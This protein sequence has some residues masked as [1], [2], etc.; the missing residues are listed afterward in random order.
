MNFLIHHIKYVFIPILFVLLTAM[1]PGPKST[2]EGP[3]SPFE[4]DKLEHQKAPDFTLKDITGTE[5]TLSALR[6][7]V[8]MINFWATWCPPCKEEMPSL[9]TLYSRMKLKRFEI[10]TVS[11]DNT[12]DAVEKYIEDH[13]FDFQVLWD[14]DQRVMR[15]YKVFSLPTTF[16]I[17]RNGV[18][19]RIFMGA[20]DW[21]DPEIV[22]EIQK[23]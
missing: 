7:T 3:V 13:D 15:A 14:E 6:G 19:V 17:D 23:L 18:I 22:K 21:T 10:L 4:I 5:R 8:V 2:G 1:G 9:N 12:L 16:L 20:Y 11:A